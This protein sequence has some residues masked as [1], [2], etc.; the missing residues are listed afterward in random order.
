MTW[1][2]LALLLAAADLGWQADAVWAPSGVSALGPGPLR[3]L[4]A[5]WDANLV[6]GG[7]AWLSAGL[8]G[9]AVARGTARGP[10]L[11]GAC[12]LWALAVGGL[13]GRLPCTTDVALLAV[14]LTAACSTGWRPGRI[15]AATEGWSWFA[16][17]FAWLVVA[18]DL[19]GRA[20]G[21][22]AG[23][24]LARPWSGGAVGAWV[25]EAGGLLAAPWLV[26]PWLAPR[27][28]AVMGLGLVAV[29]FGVSA[30]SV[31]GVMP[32]VAVAIALAGMDDDRVA[33]RE[34]RA[35]WTAP[36]G[37]AG[38]LVPLVQ[39][40]VFGAG[41]LWVVAPAVGASTTL[42]ASGVP[43]AS[44]GARSDGP[45]RLTVDGGRV[46]WRVLAAEEA[47]WALPTSWPRIDAALASDPACAEV[48]ELAARL[49]AQLAAGSAPV[50]A[51][52]GDLRFAAP[53]AATIAVTTERGGACATVASDRQD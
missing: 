39:R 6:G 37:T 3:D 19:V 8:A 47:A 26:W 34:P 23:G 16:L 15:V 4:A 18:D 13:D 53:T 45:L 30:V 42:R 5:G 31:S 36:T 29:A 17:R 25:Q 7:C 28:R 35:Q 51:A 44:H 52:V 12:V 11:F 43:T 49:V 20:L 38:Q 2:A 46:P 33:S 10:W 9:V 50:A 32:V 24:L 22:G 14:T 1:A 48:G 40:L 21:G 41:L 27:G